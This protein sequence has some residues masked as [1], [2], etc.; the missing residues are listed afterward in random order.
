MRRPIPE[1][2]R[3]AALEQLRRGRTA[4]AAAKATGVNVNTIRSW[5]ARERIGARPAIDRSSDTSL[6]DRL[7]LL[8]RLDQQSRD[9]SVT[10]TLALL[11]LAPPEPTA[12]ESDEP[13]EVIALR[14]IRA[15]VKSSE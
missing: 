13:A 10:A 2:D 14:S 8:R 7:E 9:G 4:V 5:K 12:G 1:R 6:P 3:E 15:R 11:K